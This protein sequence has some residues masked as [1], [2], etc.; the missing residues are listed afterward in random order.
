MTKHFFMKLSLS[1]LVAAAFI[2]CTGGSNPGFK[3]AENVIAKTVA[4]LEWERLVKEKPGT[5]LDVRTQDEFNAGFVPDAVL[6]DWYSETF[7]DEVAKLDKTL[8]IYVYCRSGGRSKRAMERMSGLGFLEI[9]NLEGGMQTW[10]KAH[11]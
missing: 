1:L 9:Y 4:L 10:K 5:V 7:N 6:I 11:P 2:A 3:A 8:P